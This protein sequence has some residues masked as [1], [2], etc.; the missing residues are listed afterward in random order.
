M[1]G[2]CCWLDVPLEGDADKSCWSRGMQH[3]GNI[4]GRG[5]P[6]GK[7]HG[8]QGG[9]GDCPCDPPGVGVLWN[10]GMTE[11]GIMEWLKLEPWNHWFL[12][13]Q[14]NCSPTT[15]PKCPHMPH[16]HCSEI[17]PGMRIPPWPA[18]SIKEF[19]PD[20]QP[21]ANQNKEQTVAYSRGKIEGILV[22]NSSQDEEFHPRHSQHLGPSQKVPGMQVLEDGTSVGPFPPASAGPTLGLVEPQTPF[23]FA[24]CAPEPGLFP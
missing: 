6:S 17:P 8:C 18:L 9:L 12:G 2:P 20:F 5:Q 3:L 19:L 21:H 4:H 23:S 13:H 11:V 16:P 22:L 7:P 10:R 1:G 15:D 24:I 14:S